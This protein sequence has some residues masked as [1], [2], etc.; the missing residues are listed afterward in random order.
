MTSFHANDSGGH[1]VALLVASTQTIR[2]DI[3]KHTPDPRRV[4]VV[5]LSRD[6]CVDAYKILRPVASS[7]SEV[8]EGSNLWNMWLVFSLVYYPSASGIRRLLCQRRRWN[9]VAALP[10]LT[11][12]SPCEVCMRLVYPHQ[13][14]CYRVPEIYTKSCRI[15]TTRTTRTRPGPCR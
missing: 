7:V 6:R 1:L 12:T 2:A 10:A 9:H 13:Y 4:A 5:V 3:C 8:A 11:R 14:P 15:S